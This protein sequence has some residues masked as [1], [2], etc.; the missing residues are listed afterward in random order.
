MVGI[1]GPHVSSQEF[2]AGQYGHIRWVRW[3]SDAIG[4]GLAWVP[5]GPG[6]AVRAYPATVTATS[7]QN[8]R[9]T[10]LRWWFGSGSHRYTEWDRLMRFGRDYDWRYVRSSGNG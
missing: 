1:T 4:R 10:S 5:N 2:R 3:S 7:V 8:G 6:G 9:Y